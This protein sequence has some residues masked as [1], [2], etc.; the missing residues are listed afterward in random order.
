MMIILSGANNNEKIFIQTCT[1]FGYQ[2]R[3][4]NYF[5]SWIPINWIFRTFIP[6]SSN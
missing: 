3:L 4:M 2:E 6:S 5:N 1:I